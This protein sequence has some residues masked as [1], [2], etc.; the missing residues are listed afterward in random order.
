M[1]HSHTGRNRKG[2]KYRLKYI[3]GVDWDKCVGCGVCIKACGIH[4]LKFVNTEKGTKTKIVDQNKCLG[5]GHC[6]QLC[7][8][9]ALEYKFMKRNNA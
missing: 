9:D 8:N 6:I 7:P 1:N 2:E 4:I 3:V 5:E